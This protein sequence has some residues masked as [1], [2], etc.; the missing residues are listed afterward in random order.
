MP[1][2]CV[3]LVLCG[4]IIASAISSP[5]GAQTPTRKPYKPVGVTLPTPPADKSLDAFR[6]QLAGIAQRK[7]RAALSRIVAKTFFWEGDFGGMY[8]AKKPAFDNLATALR[9]NEADGRGW[10]A[11]LAFATEPSIGRGAQNPNPRCAPAQPNYDDADL[12]IITESTNTDVVDWSYPRTAKLQLREKP[13]ADAPV[14]E[15]LDSHLI[16]V[17]G[18]DGKGRRDAAQSWLRVVAPSGKIGFAPPG[19]LISP[20]ADRLCFGKDAGG[21]RIVGYV[22]AGD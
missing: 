12:S 11:L 3:R 5:V 19:T 2:V 4:L 8:D 16:Q 18:A 21:W 13:E 20:L 9:L 1:V 7:D 17:I 14:V 10:A 22:G 6:K 15:T